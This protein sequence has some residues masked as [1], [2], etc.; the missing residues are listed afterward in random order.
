MSKKVKESGVK[1][2]FVIGLVPDVCENYV[3]VK[4]LWMKSGVEKL[5]KRFTVATDLKFSV[6]FC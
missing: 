2:S 3:N 4:R 1:K 5:D 6:T